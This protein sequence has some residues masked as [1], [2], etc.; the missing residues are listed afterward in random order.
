VMTSSH[1]LHLTWQKRPTRRAKE[2]YLYDKRDL[3]VGQKRPTCMTKETYLYGKRDL[4]MTSSDAQ[5][6]D[7]EED[8]LFSAHAMNQVDS[9]RGSAFACAARARA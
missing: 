9:E 4:L 1:G 2:T 6:R 7:G 3:L 5:W 8:D